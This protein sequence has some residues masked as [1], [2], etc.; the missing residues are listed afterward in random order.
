MSDQEYDYDY[1]YDQN[2][3][4][5]EEDQDEIELENNFNRAEDEWKLNPD[6]A[7]QL[8]NEVIERE[9]SKDINSRKWSFKSYQFLIQILIQKSKFQDNLIFQYIQGFLE[10]LDRQYKTEGD[11]A[12]KIVVDSLMNS[13]NSHLISIVLPNLLDKLKYMNQI[14]IY[15]GASMKLCKDYYQ[16]GNYNKLEEIINNIQTVLD[17]SQI[18]D[19]DR[20]KAFLAELLAYRVLLYNST[21][22]Q[23]QIK[24]LYRQLLKSNLDLLEPYISG[25]INLTIGQQKALERQYEQSRKK[26][27]EA[28]YNF[29]DA[30][31]PEAKQAL[32]YA[33]VVSIL[34]N[35]KM[36]LFDDMKSK[37]Y[38][39]DQNVKV[40]QDLRISYEQQNVQNFSNI[41][42]SEYFL[43]DIFL[44][45]LKPYMQQII[46][47]VKI[48][49]YIKCYSTIKLDYLSKQ[50]LIEIPV[51][52]Q[53]IQG[54]ITKKQFNGLID[55]IEGY[56]EIRREV[57]ETQTKALKI[58]VDQIK[59]FDY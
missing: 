54:L 43:N 15:C 12:L 49:R 31:S 23:E 46:V 39:Q 25:V 26:L 40:F 50:L 18:Q 32:I 37:V 6:L 56:L 52:K 1:D 45:L 42:N 44:A 57:A 30:C 20:K 53:Y 3:I 28:F 34:E 47:E 4:D 13:N 55:E 17:N 27:M 29:L 2:Q 10:L 14:G 58:I 38:E 5:Q 24:P 33:S 41:I 48:L 22:R 7:Y 9:K 11:K 8:F 35:F 59:I 21:N 19:E 51:L 16:K 36:N